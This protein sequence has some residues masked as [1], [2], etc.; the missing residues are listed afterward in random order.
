MEMEVGGVWQSTGVLRLFPQFPQGAERLEPGQPRGGVNHCSGAP[1]SSAAA[2]RAQA[3][4]RGP[5]LPLQRCCCC[6]Q[7]PHCCSAKPSR[8]A[9]PA[10]RNGAVTPG[11]LAEGGSRQEKEGD[12]AG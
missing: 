10:L 3:V 12:P 5:H 1:R 4:L 6:C 7:S 8:A 9:A 11:A 2:R